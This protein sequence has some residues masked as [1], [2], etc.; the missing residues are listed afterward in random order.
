MG[1]LIIK[2]KQF[3][4]IIKLRAELRV[5][6]IKSA[7][8]P[9][10]ISHVLDIVCEKHSLWQCVILKAML[11]MYILLTKQRRRWFSLVHWVNIFQCA[12][13]H[14]RKSLDHVQYKARCA[15]FHWPLCWQQHTVTLHWLSLHGGCRASIRQLLCFL[16]LDIQS[17]LIKRPLFSNFSGRSN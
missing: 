9:K 15:D 1:R 2:C 7:R 4:K 8:K 17:W 6:G 13:Q 12:Y 14:Q 11:I 3:L 16:L 10:Y 5:W